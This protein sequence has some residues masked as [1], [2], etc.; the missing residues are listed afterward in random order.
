MSETVL[1]S[2]VKV[3]VSSRCEI[4][5]RSISGLVGANEVCSEGSD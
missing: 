3:A 1:R 5:L 4:L 2:I